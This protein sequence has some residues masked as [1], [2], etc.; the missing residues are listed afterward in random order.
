MVRAANSAADKARW[1]CR[2][3]CG[4]LKT[5]L[6]ASLTSD[7]TKSCGCAVAKANIKRTS[8]GH[9]KRTGQ[10]DTYRCWSDMLKRCN[11]PNNWAAKY[12]SERGIKVCKRWHKFQNF[13]DDMGERPKDLT[14]DRIDNDG[15]YEP[16]NCRWA[17]RTE[18]ARN[19]RKPI[20]LP[21]RISNLVKR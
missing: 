9:S 16:K 19:R 5:V 3:D 13:L 2:C 20:Q 12:Y 10:S 14:L 7:L 1:T 17:T 4:N 8:H 18:Q 11:N 21:K 6:G 15:N